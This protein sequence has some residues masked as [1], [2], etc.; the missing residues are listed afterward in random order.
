[1]SARQRGIALLTAIILVAVAAIVAT[2]IAWQSQL[3][4][5]RGIAVFTIAQSLAIAEG[6]EAMAAYALRDNRQKNPQIVAPNQAWAKP[7]GPVEMEAGAVLEASLEDQAGKFNLNSLVMANPGGA[8]QVAGAVV[9]VQNKDAYN[10]F[11]TL[12]TDL[13]IN[14]DYAARVVDWIDSDDQAT[15]PGGAED[16]YY[17]TQQP[18]YRTPNLPITS[19]SELLA[20]GMDRTS[21]DRLAPLVTALPLDTKLNV[22]TAP[23]EVLDVFS[24]QRSYALDASEL[25]AQRQQF[26]CYPDKDTFLSGI[27]TTLKGYVQNHIGTTSQY[28]RLRTWITIGTTRF[29][30]Y[31]LIYQDTSGQIRPVLRTF[32]T[33]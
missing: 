22:C 11:V 19:V 26:N 16:T 8:G 21:Y 32:G 29:T 14:T 17:L 12:L 7:Y 27:S 20:M 25:N 13:N 9:L 3:A 6:A 31:S 24:G 18:P 30:L 4:A 1:V 10:Q 5:R 23:G 28:F 2:A 33:E 15:F